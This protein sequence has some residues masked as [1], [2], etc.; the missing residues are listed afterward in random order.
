MKKVM[1]E[2]YQA[3]DGMLFDSPDVARQYEIDTLRAGVRVVEA[4]VTRKVAKLYALYL[5]DDCGDQFEGKQHS[6]FG[7]CEI[8]KLLDLIYGHQRDGTPVDAHAMIGEV[9]V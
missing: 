2:M 1:A 8:E 4:Q 9:K 5:M 6:H 7:K 3:L